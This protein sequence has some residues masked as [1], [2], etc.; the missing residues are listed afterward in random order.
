MASGSERRVRVVRVEG[1]ENSR[2]ILALA[3]ELGGFE[4][5]A[6]A[7]RPRSSPPPEPPAGEPAEAGRLPARET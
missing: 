5:E 4:V 7:S 3:L 1:D 2:D 6:F